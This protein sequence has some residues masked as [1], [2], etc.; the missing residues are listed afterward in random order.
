MNLEEKVNTAIKEAMKAKD[1]AKLRGMRAIKSA[2][3]LFKTDGSGAELDDEN[4]IK[5][6]QKLIK[7]R[8][9]S[10]EIYEKQGR[11]DLAQTE[12]EEIA[13][14]E[15]LLPAQLSADELAETVKAIIAET[16]AASVKDMGKVMAAASKQLAGR[17]DGKAISAA[18]KEILK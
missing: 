16:G 9:D 12:R 10:L 18:V 1:Q 13:V 6:L 15:T 14:I 17:A 5:M 4:E 2:I 11:E 8:R 3:L 7:Q